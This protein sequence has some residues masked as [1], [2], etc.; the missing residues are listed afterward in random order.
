MWYYVAE[1]PWYLAG[2]FGLAAAGFLVALKLT[3]DGRNLT[4]ALIALGL[5]AVVLVVE[6][7][8]VTDAERV[9]WAVKDL[10][11]A[12]SENDTTRVISL[13]DDRV[14]FSMRDK[15]ADELDHA[16][17]ARELNDLT[18]DWLH[19]SRLTTSAGQQTHRGSAGDRK[20]VV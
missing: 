7:W 1:N 16:W 20:S 17:F 9:E 11:R 19:L 14:T 2:T 3:Q 5:A 12:L 10:V 6:Q 18:F 13:M 15:I 8:I 4:R